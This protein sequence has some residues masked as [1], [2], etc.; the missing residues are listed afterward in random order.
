M[1]SDRDLHPH[2]Q[3]IVATAGTRELGRLSFRPDVA[4]KRLTVPLVPQNGLCAVTYTVSP[5]A[6]PAEVTHKADTR[7][8]GVRFLSFDYKPPS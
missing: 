2:V 3:T 4:A 8:L 5:T 7:A 1:L 6:V